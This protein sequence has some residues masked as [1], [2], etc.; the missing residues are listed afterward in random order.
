MIIYY[1]HSEKRTLAGSTVHALSYSC[2]SGFRATVPKLVQLITHFLWQKSW[3]LE[4]GDYFQVTEY[5]Q[6]CTHFL[7]HKLYSKKTV[8]FLPICRKLWFTAEQI[9]SAYNHFSIERGVKGVSVQDLDSSSLNCCPKSSDTEKKKVE[10]WKD[11]WALTR[12]QR[13]NQLI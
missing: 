7:C 6:I 9:W 3:V 1:D 10:T 13:G 2:F 12:N 4:W 11:H 5:I 8:L